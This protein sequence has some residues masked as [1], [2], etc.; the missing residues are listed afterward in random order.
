MPASKGPI[1][2]R[3]PSPLSL[4]LTSFIR[5]VTK[6]VF[7]EDAVVRSYGEDATTLALHVECSC[8]PTFGRAEMIGQLLTRVDCIPTVDVTRRGSKVRGNAKIAY[9]QGYIL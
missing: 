7:G 9:R 2:P 3:T 6:S 5:E 1:P 4:E 8:A